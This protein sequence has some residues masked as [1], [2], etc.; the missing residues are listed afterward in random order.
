MRLAPL[1]LLLAAAPLFAVPPRITHS[2][3]TSTNASADLGRQIRNA[4]TPWIGYS[5][6]AINS[7]A[8]VC[9]FDWE[10][11]GRSGGRGCMLSDEGS[12][13]T[14]VDRDD[15]HVAHES[16][17][18]FYRVQSG[19]IE[20]VRHFST[21]CPLD[22][23]GAE[24]TWIENV[25]PKASVALLASLAGD[26]ERRGRRAM[27]ALAMH[28]E[29]A[30]GDQLE[31]FARAS[32]NSDNV[33][34][35]AL[36]W[37]AETR[38]DRALDVARSVVRDANSSRH[39]REKAIFALSQIKNTAATDELIRVARD[40]D[41]ETRGK[42]LFWLSQK[43]GEKAV[44]ALKD[45]VNNDPDDDIKAKAVFGISQLPNDRSIPL[46][47]ELAR[48]HPNRNVRKKA[49]FW[50]GQKND[51]RALDAIESFLK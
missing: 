41:H 45:A 5:V 31:Q 3:I 17:V 25:E 32:R 8:V 28:A 27:S 11:D 38:G 43:A 50:L 44:S 18:I 24:V 34:G 7:Y 1:A 4:G 13:F 37:L 30:A 6:P 36:F 22:A 16:V 14:N 51:P 19:A 40:G 26:D 33:R 2:H 42:A 10:G 23:A 35:D 20:R 47:V 39:L 46:L 9:C 12:S 21:D 48:T 15:M 29:P 49:I